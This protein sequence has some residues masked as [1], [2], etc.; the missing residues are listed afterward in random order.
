MCTSRQLWNYWSAND[1]IDC[2]SIPCVRQ[3]SCAT[4]NSKLNFAQGSA[5]LLR[6]TCYFNWYFIR[7]VN[8]VGCRNRT[9]VTICNSKTI[10]TGRSGIYSR[11]TFCSPSVVKSTW[12]TASVCVYNRCSAMALYCIS[13]NRS[14]CNS[15]RILRSN[16]WRCCTAFRIS[17]NDIVGS[18]FSQSTLRL[19]CHT[20]VPHICIATV[21]ALHRYWNI[22]CIVV[23]VDCGCY[24]CCSHEI[25]WL[26]DFDRCVARATIGIGYRNIVCSSGQVIKIMIIVGFVYKVAVPHNNIRRGSIDEIYHYTSTVFSKTSCRLTWIQGQGHSTVVRYVN[27]SRRSTSVSV[28]YRNRMWARAQMLSRCRCVCACISAI[29]RI[30]SITLRI[31]NWEFNAAESFAGL[32]NNVIKVNTKFVW[33][34]NSY[35]VACRTAVFIGNR[36]CMRT[37][38]DILKCACAWVNSRTAISCNCHG[39]S[40]SVAKD[41]TCGNRNL[42]LRW[43]FNINR[44][45]CNTAVIISNRDRIKTEVFKCSLRLNIHIVDPMV[46]IFVSISQRTALCRHCNVELIAEAHHWRYQRCG[47]HKQSR[48]FNCRCQSAWT[49]IG[50][51]NNNRVVSCR[52]IRNFIRRCHN[53]IFSSI[54]HRRSPYYRIWWTTSYVFNI[55]TT[56]SI[57]ITSKLVGSER[58]RY[59]SSNVFDGNLCRTRTFVGIGN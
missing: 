27:R 9:T 10:R 16:T 55:D 43:F 46:W 37:S 28:G 59:G 7:I 57:A 11:N 24:G 50:I 31:W 2:I 13:D 14:N 32:C 58:E 52:Q 53:I 36:I 6:S 35:I 4:T 45:R 33:F 26:T 8:N 44:R 19:S 49:F 54:C 51:S 29:P 48:F 22:K 15:L 18:I 21:S 25:I 41:V 5:I 42:N 47:S 39:R 1:R 23:A 20:A 3:V 30:S 17:Y 12:T 38:I 34:C 56:R 40:L